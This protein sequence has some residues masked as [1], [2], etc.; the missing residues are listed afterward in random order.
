MRCYVFQFS[1]TLISVNGGVDGM[2][3]INVFFF[4]K[5]THP[6]LSVS[7]KEEIPRTLLEG[8]VRTLL[9]KVFGSS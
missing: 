8:L 9:I 2:A 3:S 7:V 5:V 6:K 1:Q 4:H